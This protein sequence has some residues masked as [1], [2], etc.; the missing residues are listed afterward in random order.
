M[1]FEVNSD[2]DAKYEEVLR[3]LNALRP[4]LPA[5]LL[6][7]ETRRFDSGKVNI[8]Q[9]ALV[10]ATAPYADMER[11][12]RRLK[13]RLSRRDGVRQSETWAIPDAKCGW[14]SISVAS[15]RLHLP[16]GQYCR[17]SRARTPTFPAEA[18]TPVAEVQHQDERELCIARRGA[19]DRGWRERRRDVR[20]KDVADVE[21]NSR[22]RPT[23]GATTASAPPS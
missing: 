17:R 19:A 5:D 18:W 9:L 13:D 7:L 3:E 1:E 22:R 4:D 11:E 2:A 16:L 21:W 8:V 14:P 23:W 12:A 20:V 10:S 15:A 6:T